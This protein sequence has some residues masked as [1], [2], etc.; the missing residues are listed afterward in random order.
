[1]S[2][3]PFGLLAD[4][5]LHSWS[6]FSTKLPSGVNSRLE[7]LLGEVE[8]AALE[9]K[10][11]GG[12]SLVF[13]GDV[14]HVR[15]SISPSV[16]NPVRDRLNHIFETHGV[17]IVIM[18]GNHDLEGRDSCR[19]GSAVTGLEGPGII[20]AQSKYGLARNMVLVPWVESIDELKLLLEKLSHDTPNRGD[21]DLILHAPI[22]GVLPGLPPHGLD[23]R[24]LA[25][26]GFKRVFAGHYHNHKCLTPDLEGGVWS[27]GALAHHTWSDINSRA[28][29]LIVH[30]DR[31]EWRKSHLPEFIDLGK[32]AEFCTPA[33]L[34]GV[35]DGN[36]IRVRVE[37]AKHSEVEKIRKELLDMGA[38]DVIVQSEPKPPVREAADRPNTVTGNKPLEAQVTAY[39]TM[40]TR[41]EIADLAA[42]HCQQVLAEASVSE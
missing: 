7:M 6:A 22:D 14:F 1:M 41:P 28:G 16:F 17:R 9:V 15:G 18:P 34:P 23:A 21:L 25:A 13:A 5:H 39:A 38:R 32:A 40:V 20:V 4:L 12:D 3:K 19:I 35:V 10:A 29:F 24:W 26:L 31:V 11:A 42:R 30:E 2:K 8:R 33:E 37:S 36:Y 27:I